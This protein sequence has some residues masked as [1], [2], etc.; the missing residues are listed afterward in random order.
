[1]GRPS[2]RMLSPREAMARRAAT[3]ALCLAA[4]L[5][6][7]RALEPATLAVYPCLPCQ[8]APV[9]DGRLDEACWRELPAMDQFYKYWTPVPQE[10]PLQTVARL[11]YDGRGLYL[12]ITLYEEQMAQ[13]RATVDRRDDP[14]TWQDDCVEI[15]IDPDTSGVSY[16]KFCTN[17]LAARY[18]EKATNL[19]LDSGWNVEGWQVQS[20]R[21]SGAWYLEVFIPWAD[22]DGRQPREGDIW[23]FD[24]VRYGWASG[25]FKGV[26]WSLGGSGASPAKFGYLVF[27]RAATLSDASLTRLAQAAAK[28]KGQSLRVLLPEAVLT[29]GAGSWQR[30]GLHDWLA[31][32]L[33]A[34]DDDLA[35]ANA[36]LA[37]LPVGQRRAALEK[38]ASDLS[39][40]LAGLRTPGR[41]DHLTPAGA[42]IAYE[43][44][45]ALRRSL[46]E[47]TWEGKLWELLAAP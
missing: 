46:R 25:G 19:V 18:D 4:V 11:G 28:T 34:A 41:A 12:G 21:G 30:C 42:A 1:M 44:S 14:L 22:L 26:S 37:A 17:A 7:A 36:T 20:T 40:K 47:V 3:V 6:S 13:I 8:P 35:R 43:A 23:S 27:S 32:A 39:T 10:P 33:Q 15:M 16:Y 24:L 38:T 2:R 45:L 9:I 5:P 31:A 29:Y